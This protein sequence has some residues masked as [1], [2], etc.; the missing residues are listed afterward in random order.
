[1][2]FIEHNNRNIAKKFAEY[3]TGEELRKYC[4]NKIEK[5][6]GSQDITVFDGAVGSGQLEQFLNLKYLYGVDV[7]K[8]SIEALKENY[9]NSSGYNKSFFEF[10]EDIKAD[11]TLMNPPFSLK[12]KDLSKI[13]QDNIKKEFPW[14]KSG[15]VDD[16]FVLKGL[17]YTKRFGFYI[18]FPGVAYRK[19]ELM[20]RK[21]V[22]NRLL[23]INE[24]RN[25]FEDTAISVLFLVID[26]EKESTTVESEVYD[27]KLKK[28]LLNAT[29][30]IDVDRWQCVREEIEKEEINIKE[31]EDDLDKMVVKKLRRHLE[32]KLFTQEISGKDND[33][34]G[35]INKINEVLDDIERRL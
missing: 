26:K 12:F 27:C 8:E 16:I 18:V 5:Y 35:F 1:M 24:I 3:I 33:I 11:V 2:T 31:L 21:E 15:V 13:E 25:A 29:I 28:V 32:V 20:L 14:K 34:Q 7:Q 10:D 6:L 17:N 30:E 19:T 9:V 4:K 22:G 23:E